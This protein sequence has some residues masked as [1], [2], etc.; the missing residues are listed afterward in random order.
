MSQKVDDDLKYQDESG[1]QGA[2]KVGLDE[3]LNADQGDESLQKWKDSLIQKNATGVKSDKHVIF[4]KLLI[5]SAGLEK[6]LEFTFDQVKQ[7]HDDKAILFTIKGGESF[8]IGYQYRVFNDIVMGLRVVQKVSRLGMAIMKGQQMMGCFAPQEQPHEFFLEE[9]DA[10]G[11]A[12]ARGTYH[13]KGVFGDDDEG[14]GAFGTLE[15]EFDIR[16]DW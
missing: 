13:V 3:A 10:P 9:I 5:S 6:R 2:K 8:K 7:S 4:D 14:D 11:S 15:F 12:I 1:Y 16:K